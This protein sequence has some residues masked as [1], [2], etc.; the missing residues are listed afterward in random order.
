MSNVP[1]SPE[2]VPNWSERAAILFSPA[3]EG[4]W[5]PGW[6]R[7]DL[8]KCAAK[9]LET[10]F[11]DGQRSMERWRERFEALDRLYDQRRREF[12]EEIEAAQRAQMEADCAMLISAAESLPGWACLTNTTAQLIATRIRAAFEMKV[13]ETKHEL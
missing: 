11:L 7:R 1:D 2:M 9:M 6:M 13:A 8:E 3:A 4:K 12:L 5:M 10:A